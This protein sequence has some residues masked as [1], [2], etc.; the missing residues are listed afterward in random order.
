MK[1][2]IIFVFAVLMGCANAV[3]IPAGECPHRTFVQKHLCIDGR[4]QDTW[5]S[6]SWQTG[7]RNNDRDLYCKVDNTGNIYKDWGPC[8]QNHVLIG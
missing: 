1:L 2:S 6:G 5:Q 4:C 7:E 8:N 3:W